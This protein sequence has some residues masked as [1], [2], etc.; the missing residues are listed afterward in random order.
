LVKKEKLRKGHFYPIYRA[1]E[2]V[3]TPYATCSP[4][5][6]KRKSIAGLPSLS[7]NS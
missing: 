4:D 5:Y 3:D 7:R 6:F 1:I 2:V